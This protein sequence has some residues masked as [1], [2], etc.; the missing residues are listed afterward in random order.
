MGRCWSSGRSCS[1]DTWLAQSRSAPGLT[2]EIPTWLQTTST[3]LDNL[4]DVA[5]FLDEAP[6]DMSDLLNSPSIDGAPTD[7]SSAPWAIRNAFE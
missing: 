4:D 6:W 1:A 5:A 7:H 3:E 2:A